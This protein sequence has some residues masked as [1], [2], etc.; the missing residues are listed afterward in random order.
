M[1]HL[2]CYIFSLAGSVSSDNLIFPKIL[3]EGQKDNMV[4]K[5]VCSTWQEFPE[6]LRKKEYSSKKQCTQFRDLKDS[7]VGL[8][9]T[10]MRYIK[11]V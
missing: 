9:L 11:T 10:Q 2:A 6:M 8:Y 1:C 3:A 7:E 4:W 5:M